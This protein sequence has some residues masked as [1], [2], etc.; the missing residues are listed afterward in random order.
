MDEAADKKT[1]RLVAGRARLYCL[2]TALY[3]ITGVRRCW[4]NPVP[5]LGIGGTR[6]GYANVDVEG[7][8]LVANYWIGWGC[9][10]RL[11]L[12]NGDG[13]WM[14]ARSYFSS[15]GVGA[16]SQETLPLS[17]GL[18]NDIVGGRLHV[19][20]L[21]LSALVMSLEPVPGQPRLSLDGKLEIPMGVSEC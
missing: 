18:L 8:W 20:E 16:V 5:V 6:I 11:N 9:P 13:V 14:S 1:M 3:D 15:D 2:K 4:Q 12:E 7:S 17:L 19:D 21:K 10:E